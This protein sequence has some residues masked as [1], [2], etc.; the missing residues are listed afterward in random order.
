MYRLACAQRTLVRE[1]VR[2][3]LARVPVART[4]SVQLMAVGTG[5]QEEYIVT[6]WIRPK[7]VTEHLTGSLRQYKALSGS[8]GGP[9]WSR[10]KSSGS[11]NM[12]KIFLLK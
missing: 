8:G 6:Q 10:R 7:P 12:S 2:G 3:A 11:A 1:S 4:H 9:H 5:D